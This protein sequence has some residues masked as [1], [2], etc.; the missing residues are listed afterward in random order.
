MSA[1]MA[2]ALSSDGSLA[3]SG[4]ADFGV[5]VWDLDEGGDEEEEV[6]VFFALR[7]CLIQLWM[8]FRCRAGCWL[9]VGLVRVQVRGGAG[10]EVGGAGGPTIGVGKEIRRHPVVGQTAVV[11]NVGLCRVSCC[12]IDLCC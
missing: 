8:L 9:L 10:D 5:C 1:V 3:A 4:G 11:R 6:R 7:N 2:L 12:E